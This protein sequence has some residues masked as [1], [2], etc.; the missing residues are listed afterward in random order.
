MAEDLTGGA[1]APA[2]TSTVADTAPA[3][4]AAEPSAPKVEVTPRNAIDRAFAAVEKQGEPDKLATPAPAPAGERERNPDGTFKPA[5]APVAATPPA[6]EAPKPVQTPAGD[7]PS[8]FSADAK[9]AWKDAPEPVRAEVARM[10]RELTQGIETYRADAKAYSDTYKPFA[11]MAARSNLDASATL[12]NYVNIDMLL[13]KD[14]GAGIAQIFKNK[15]QDVRAWAA[16]LAGQPAPTPQPQDQTIAELRAELATIKHSLG[17]VSQTVEQQRSEGINRS[18]EGYVAS[19]PEADQKLFNELDAEIA[20]HLR[21]PGSTLADAF[22]RAK[23]DAEARYT[24]MFGPRP[25]PAPSPSPAPAAPT[26]DPAQTRPGNLQISGAPGTGSN[27][28]TRKTPSSP[29]AAVDSAF[30]QLGI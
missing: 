24:R 23:Q 3:P 20:A 16:Q 14:F 12:A 5:A 18:L 6:T 13:A 25:T 22:A 2:D 21:D 7:A 11:E 27:P 15:G 30:A 4:A 26:P 17:G 19:L 9:A 28:A 29:R 8:R 10:E 1:P